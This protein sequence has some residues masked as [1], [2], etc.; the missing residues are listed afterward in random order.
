MMNEQHVLK[1]KCTKKR[2]VM[3]SVLI[4]LVEVRLQV[5]QS[6]IR[7][8]WGW[9]GAMLLLIVGIPVQI[10]TGRLVVFSV[11]MVTCVTIHSQPP[12]LHAAASNA[13]APSS[14]HLV[15]SKI[16]QDRLHANP[17]LLVSTKKK[18]E[19]LS[20]YPASPVDTRTKLLQP[21]QQ[22]V[23]IVDKVNLQHNPLALQSFI[24]LSP[25]APT[26]APTL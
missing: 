6:A 7:Q 12:P 10:R 3:G 11:V 18:L 1:R 4:W 5:L 9:S 2:R 20:A 22:H 25:L 23:N 15:P 17:A 16:S 26:Q 13:P 21:Q 24:F 14:A 19:N 8:L